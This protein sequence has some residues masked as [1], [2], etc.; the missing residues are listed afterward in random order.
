LILE[1]T[2]LVADTLDNQP[3]T[4]N[5]ETMLT[6]NFIA[7]LCELLGL[8][9]KQLMASHAVE[10]IVSR[11]AVIVFVNAAPI[12]FKTAQQSSFHELFKRAVNGRSADIIRI[13]FARKLVD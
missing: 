9:F 8:K 12:Q 3:M 7:K 6:S 11:V 1:T 2:A 10:V 4:A 5:S 13:P